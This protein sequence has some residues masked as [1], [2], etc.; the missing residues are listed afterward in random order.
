MKEEPLCPFCST[1]MWY[2][3]GGKTFHTFECGE[4]KV[5]IKF[6]YGSL[7]QARKRLQSLEHRR[8]EGAK[9]V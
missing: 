8:Q 7:R 1:I 3:D 2:W 5:E 9:N 6:H 4:C